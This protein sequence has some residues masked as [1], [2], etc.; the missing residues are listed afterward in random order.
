MRREKMKR[1]ARSQK[2]VTVWAILLFVIVL[3]FGG[4][5]G[6]KLVPLYL[7][8]FKVDKAIRGA[9][10]RGVAEQTDDVIRDTLLRRLDIDSVRRFTTRNFPQYFTIEKEGAQVTIRVDYEAEEPLFYNISLLVKFAE[11]YKSY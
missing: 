3:S 11:A 10:Q 6:L 8:W 2:G 5:F 4:I 7:E 9:L 1:L